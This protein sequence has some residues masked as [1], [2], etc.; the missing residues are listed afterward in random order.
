[1]PNN[2]SHRRPI[3]RLALFLVCAILIFLAFNTLYSFTNTLHQLDVVEAER[4]RWQRPVDVLRA[5]DL[6]AGNTVVDL[7]SGAG[8]FTLKLSPAVAKRGQVLAVDLRRLSLFFLW[9][10]AVLR[11]QHNVHVVLGEEDNPRLPAGAVDAVLI[12]NTYHEFRNPELMIEHIFRALRPSGRLVV[13]DR[14]PPATEGQHTH[15]VP[16]ANVESELQSRGFDI[17]S[18]Q[19]RFIDR[20]GDD[21]WWLLVARK[22]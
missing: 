14:A 6:R 19:D 20:P 21:L 3:L 4:D 9:T 1:M 13:V 5:L 8:Y 10:R 17:V 11:G 15:E 2:P 7:G 18:R 16:L 12:C 22:P